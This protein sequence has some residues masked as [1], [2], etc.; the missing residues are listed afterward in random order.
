M[1]TLPWTLA[2]TQSGDVTVIAA[3]LPLRSARSLPA[4]VAWAW[5]VRR[6]LR[7]APGLAG[8]AFA[9]Q[10]CGSALWTVSAWQSRT[11]LTG[12]EHSGAHRGATMALRPRLRPATF[13]VWSCQA[14]ELPVEWPEVRR[15]ITAGAK[16]GNLTGAA[17]H[18]TRSG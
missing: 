4:T 16:P 8:Y 10:I 7:D 11:E 12:F 9:F 18:R 14:T 5:R 1:I 2:A 17:Q 6:A 3:R 13:A 15:R